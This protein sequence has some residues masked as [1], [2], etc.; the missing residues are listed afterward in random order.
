MSIYE[1][2]CICSTI[3]LL[4]ISVHLLRDD[5]ES[6]VTENTDSHV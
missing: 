3:L 2:K 5:A 6:L 1:D 4:A